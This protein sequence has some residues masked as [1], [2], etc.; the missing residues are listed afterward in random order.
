MRA[1]ETEC[2]EDA[3]EGVCLESPEVSAAKIV[4][5]SFEIQDSGEGLG[6]R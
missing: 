3:V 5:R 6:C 1:E 2:V 4:E